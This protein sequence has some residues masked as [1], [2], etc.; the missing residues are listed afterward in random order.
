MK[1]KG[2]CKKKL[3]NKG[4]SLIEVIVAMVIFT[5]AFVPLLRTFVLSAKSAA[6]AKEQQRV[7]TVAQSV[8]EGFKAYDIE[9]LCLQFNGVKPM[10]VYSTNVDQP[11]TFGENDLDGDGS[12]SVNGGKFVMPADVDTYN[13]QFTMSNVAIADSDVDTKKYDIMIDVEPTYSS[14]LVANRNMNEYLDAVY[15]QGEMQNYRDYRMVLQMAI[16]KLNDYNV[17]QGEIYEEITEGTLDETQLNVGKHT[18]I[19]ISNSGDVYEVK[20]IVEYEC[21]IFNYTFTTKENGVAT[22]I[23]LGW[24]ISNG[25][26]IHYVSTHDDATGS[27]YEK[28]YDNTQT[29]PTTSLEKIYYF[30][31]PAYKDNSDALIKTE[32]FNIYN[33][34]GKTI[35]MYLIKQKYTSIPVGTY[36]TCEAGYEPLINLVPGGSEV[37]LYHNLSTDLSGNGV[38][39]ADKADIRPDEFKNAATDVIIE[40][41]KKALVYKVKVSVYDQG[42]RDAG[43]EAKLVL[44]GSVNSR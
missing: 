8:M 9:E 14:T 32:D 3:N 27:D 6:R 41:G 19:Y 30:Y 7:T 24:D 38:S 1:N 17:A 40:E 36:T 22:D 33:N 37:K 35:D 42:E 29:S 26:S 31:Y 34:S 23:S 39:L 28:F 44:E 5:I 15:V 10:Q 4:M 43:G 2:L 16:Q 25:N 13:Y 12:T 20:H 18:K 21:S 11:F